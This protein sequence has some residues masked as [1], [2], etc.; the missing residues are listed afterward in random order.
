MFH[1]LPG[2]G[3]FTSVNQMTNHEANELSEYLRKEEVPRWQHVGL[4]VGGPGS[5]P[6]AGCTC[7]LP[8]HETADGTRT[9]GLGK[10]SSSA[11]AWRPAK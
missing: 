4:A 7:T 9:A 8:F 5:I 10:P 1:Q 2:G 6:G 3:G 11:S